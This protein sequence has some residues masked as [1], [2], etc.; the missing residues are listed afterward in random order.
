[1][2]DIVIIG[3]GV[4]GCG[5]A[6]AL[7]R[8]D[9]R[10][11]LIEKE[12]DVS[13]GASKANSG[14]VHGGYAGKAGTLKGKLCI[15]GNKLF[16]SLNKELQFGYKK[17]G[18]LIIG[19]TENDRHNLMNQYENGLKIGQT[20]FKW[21]N[22]DEILEIEPNINP[23]VLC[24][25]YTPSIGITSPYEMT[26]ALCENAIE[27]G[28]ELLL[29]H[30]VTH[31]HLEECYHIETSEG[32]IK[33]KWLINAA[34]LNA[35]EINRMLGNNDLTICPRRGQYILLGKDQN[36][37]NHVIFQT[38]TEKGKGILVTPTVHGNLMIG[39]DAEEL[40]EDP[41]TETSI[42]RLEKI[43][44]QAKHSVESFDIKRSLTTFSGIRA[45]SSNQDFLIQY[46]SDFGITVG[47]IDSPGLTSSP[48]IA[49]YVVDLIKQKYD[50]IE[51]KDYN[52]Y[53]KSY[54]EI[55]NDT[56]I[57][58]CEEQGKNRILSALD[59]PIKL[60]STDAIKR[61]V[62]AGMGNCQ[63]LRCQPLVKEIISDYHH[64][65]KDSV[66]VRTE[67]YKPNRV[68]IKEIRS[69]KI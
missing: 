53:R 32:M 20:D 54:F 50:L 66:K 68:S 3:A 43:V 4:V 6:R 60:T 40:L 11:A 55:E 41:I 62:R 7:S 33:S 22:R 61:R 38:P 19:F 18:G 69:L 58:Q 31:I 15:E 29:E 9:V 42:I 52:P 64:I 13:L 23:N 2:Y 45:I 44:K 10:V 67:S 37:L 21:L 57:C 39:P 14:I 34:G 16:E 30:E 25:L 27:N 1:M 5:I 63:G 17:I 12:A 36:K 24:A 48:A 49:E 28:V 47:G 35:G 26:I 59:G 65:K 51:K 8:Y 46:V 56:I